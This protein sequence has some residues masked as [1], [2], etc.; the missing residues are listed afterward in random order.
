MARQKA[1]TYINLYDQYSYLCSSLKG[2]FELF[3]ADGKLKTLSYLYDEIE[4]IF[5]L[6]LSL[7]Y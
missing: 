3:D 2:L 6:M 5:E 1:K 7:N 4:V